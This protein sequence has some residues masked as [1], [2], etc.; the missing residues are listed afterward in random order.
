[1][2]EGTTAVA[3]NGTSDREQVYD[4][5]NGAKAVCFINQQS[6]IQ[7][8]AGDIRVQSLLQQLHTR[9]QLD[10]DDLPNQG[11]SGSMIA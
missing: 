5:A 9:I 11:E 3:S 8:K 1:M 4:S 7:R 2:F 10:Q 6:Q